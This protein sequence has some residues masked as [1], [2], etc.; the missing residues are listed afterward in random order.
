MLL[1]RGRDT[2]QVTDPTNV[3]VVPVKLR[4]VWYKRR[5]SQA[6]IFSDF[7][8][9]KQMEVSRLP[10]ILLCCLLEMRPAFGL[11]HDG[12]GEREFKE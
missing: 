12:K 11:V 1:V 7:S 8:F 9:W 4:R 5:V 10:F 2:L 3:V 6:R